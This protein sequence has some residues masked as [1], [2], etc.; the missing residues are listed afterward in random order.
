MAGGLIHRVLSPGAALM[1]GQQDAGICSL[2]AQRLSAGRVRVHLLGRASVLLQGPFQLSVAS[3]FGEL[4]LCMHWCAVQNSMML[5]WHLL[6][7]WGLLY[8]N[9][10]LYHVLL[11]LLHPGH[12]SLHMAGLVCQRGLNQPNPDP[13][14]PARVTACT[15]LT[16]AHVCMHLR[17]NITSRP[18]R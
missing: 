8:A 9:P 14:S 12:A 16:C 11:N 4:H 15:A 13:L 3:L 2:G 10:A 18:A 6:R 7:L 17:C 1:H 5:M